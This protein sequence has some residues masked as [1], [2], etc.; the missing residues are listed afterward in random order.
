MRFKENKPRSKPSTTEEPNGRVS[1]VP[2]PKRFH[3]VVANVCASEALE[4]P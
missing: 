2:S 1:L 4:K 3:R